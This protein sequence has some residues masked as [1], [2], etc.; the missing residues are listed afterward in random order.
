MVETL[1]KITRSFHQF[2]NH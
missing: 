1:A 2:K